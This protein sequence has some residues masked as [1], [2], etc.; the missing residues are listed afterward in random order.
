[1]NTRLPAAERRKM[2]VAAARHLFAQ[3]GFQA[4]TTRDIAR[5]VGVSDALLYT[6]FATKQE[7][8]D[9]ILQEGLEQFAQMPA[10]EDSPTLRSLLLQLGTAFLQVITRQRD[11]F[12]LVVSEH[13]YIAR[14]GRFAQFLEYGAQHFGHVLQ[15]RAIQG[16]AKAD[17]DGYLVARQFMGA[18]VAYTILQ[19]ALG[20]DLLH[21]L[22]NQQY[23]DQLIE[24]T[25]QG[26]SSSP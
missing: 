7:V 9:A 6:Y 18:L 14:D 21:P 25:L 4:T 3:Q 24:T 11:F 12:V 19:D 22:D 8:L 17:I 1:M 2:I 16:E 15:Q 20:M 5:A 23:L 10:Y 26:I 13:Q